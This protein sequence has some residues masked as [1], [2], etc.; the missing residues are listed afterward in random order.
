MVVTISGTLEAPTR[1]IL[2]LLRNLPKVP[3]FS[4]PRKRWRTISGIDFETVKCR[5]CAEGNSGHSFPEADP[6]RDYLIFIDYFT[7]LEAE[8]RIRIH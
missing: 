1:T 5:P 7:L 8:C 2:K 3:V 4:H 6:F